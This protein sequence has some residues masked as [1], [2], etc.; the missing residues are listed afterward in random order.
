[1]ARGARFGSRRPPTV[2]AVY[3]TFWHFAA[4]R[5]EIF[6]RR[7]S[8]QEG[9]WTTDRVLLEHRFTN[10]Y[11]AADRVSQ[12]LI[13]EVVYVGNQDPVEVVFRTLLFKLFNKV[14]TWQ[15]LEN[16]FG[17][18]EVETFS[19]EDYDHVLTR[20]Y[21]RGQRIYSA[22]YIMPAAL[23]GVARKHRTHLLLLKQMMEDGLAERLA[24]CATMSDGYE[25]LK[26]YRG[27]GAFLSYQLI[28]DLN[29]S[30]V[31]NF[32]EMDF[33]VPGPGAAS[34]LAKCFSDPG[35]YSPAELI[36]Y[37]TERQHEEFSR[38]GLH[39][40]DLWGRPLQLVDCQNLFCEVDKYARVV[41][42]DVR[43]VGTRSRIKQKFTASFEPLT[44]SFPPKWNI[45]GRVRDQ[46]VSSQPQSFEQAGLRPPVPAPAR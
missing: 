18:I 44:V 27:M 39:F 11:R 46:A 14:A 42:P 9:P 29:Y 5:Q 19:V 38:R 4:L 22:A 34:G 37:V 35:D 12:Y 3:D 31:V 45:N 24:S 43:G 26:S 16:E 40:N 28:T 7:V 15:M 23:P 13:N 25:L 36:R 41:H 20:A 30:T 8:G 21:E 6:H 2:T 32:S 17:R 1:M 33:V 10:A